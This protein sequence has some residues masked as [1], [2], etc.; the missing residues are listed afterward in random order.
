MGGARTF[1]GSNGQCPPYKVGLMDKERKGGG[2]LLFNSYYI[3][4]INFDVI[5]A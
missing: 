3:I 2:V 4:L 1:L 5:I